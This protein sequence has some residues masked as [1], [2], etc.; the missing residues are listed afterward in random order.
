MTILGL[1]GSQQLFSWSCAS[2]MT[3][4]GSSWKIS[5]SYWYQDI[6][7]CHASIYQW[8]I[9][10]HTA[11]FTLSTGLNA[12]TTAHSL[13]LVVSSRDPPATPT[14]ILMFLSRACTNWALATCTCT[15][16]L[17][18]MWKCE[19]TLNWIENTYKGGLELNHFESSWFWLKSIQFWCECD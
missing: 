7:G 15:W 16:L 12:H 19:S 3:S 6:C 2:H 14:F 5:L 8:V 10:A 18:C 1:T 9:C 11:L 4:H 17:M 13:E